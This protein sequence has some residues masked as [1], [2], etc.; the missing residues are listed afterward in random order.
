[1]K[2]KINLLFLIFPVIYLFYFG[3]TYYF[4]GPAWQIYPQDLG[5]FYLF[6]GY[7]LFTNFEVNHTLIHPGLTL[8]YFYTLIYVL[9]SI[10]YTR[11][12][13]T[14][15]TFTNP[16][17]IMD[18]GNIISVIVL[19]YLIWVIGLRVKQKFQNLYY[20]FFVQSF[21]IFLT[22]QY[23]IL[24]QFCSP[25][26]FLLISTLLVLCQILNVEK[27]KITNKKIFTIS[28]II[29]AGIFSKIIY[30]FFMFFPFF[31]LR[32]TQIKY[33]LIF[34][35]ILFTL[36][37]FPLIFSDVAFAKFKGDLIYL[38]SS[39]L[40]TQNSSSFFHVI[41]LIPQ[42]FKKIFDESNLFFIFYFGTLLLFFISI[43]LKDKKKR[44]FCHDY[45]FSI[46]ITIFSLI[47][48][49]IARPSLKYVYFYL[50][51]IILGFLINLEI[52]LKKKK[53]KDTLVIFFISI[54][55]VNFSY[56]SKKNINKAKKLKMDVTNIQNFFNNETQP[57][58]IIAGFPSSNIGTAIYNAFT[59]TS[60]QNHRQISEYSKLNFFHYNLD[61]TLFSFKYGTISVEEL[62]ALYEN[63]FY[64]NNKTN[65]Y[66]K[67]PFEPLDTLNKKIY[68]GNN[69]DIEKI[70]AFPTESLK[71]S[72]ILKKNNYCKNNSV[73]FISSKKE[74]VKY[75]K[76]TL[77][78]QISKKVLN[79]QIQF[80]IYNKSKKIWKNDKNIR[81]D[82]K[83]SK[84][85]N[86]IIIEFD[87]YYLSDEI[88]IIIDNNFFEQINFVKFY[89]NL[90][91]KNYKIIPLDYFGFKE[92]HG[93]IATSKNSFFEINTPK[94]PENFYFNLDSKEPI[95]LYEFSSS[96]HG[97]ESI[98]R[99]PRS[100]RLFGS[101]NKIVW[102]KIDERKNYNWKK[103]NEKRKFSIKNNK[104]K[105]K[106]LKFS[107]YENN[108]K[109]N[110]FR[111]AQLKIYT[112]NKSNKN[113]L[114][115]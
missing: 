72:E 84:H 25:E 35:I 63:I 22:L 76:I 37:S 105:F 88:K 90:Y 11:D 14:E 106:F 15:I 62:F 81:I 51:I 17:L 23:F 18:L 38:L 104:E 103:K 80:L 40:G 8:T 43:P 75:I 107:F 97:L 55:L 89:S 7:N 42:S 110:I 31:F 112:Q 66:P 10:F 77:D 73:C 45:F 32:K 46:F 34:F 87:K 4:K 82:Y 59:N 2:N 39:G 27:K 60:I 3:F 67:K 83:K 30:F 93:T 16:Q 1:M 48:L 85:F 21:F 108:E 98:T 19:F 86:E 50:P 20:G 92:N 5:Y 13:L 64:W 56:H 113:C 114:L 109:S 58:A 28:L 74:T 65:F 26:N 9:L 95:S 78:K 111:F 61:Q 57:F 99:M 41:K 91:C 115:N 102:H 47:I 52:L 54:I 24:Y 70:L 100:W 49:V 53:I 33:Y 68:E 6:T 29:V 79:S 69:E 71:K 94:I 36:F 44:D 12:Q 96:S 101:N